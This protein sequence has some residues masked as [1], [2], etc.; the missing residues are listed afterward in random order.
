MKTLLL[1][2]VL[3]IATMLFV[4]FMGRN[5]YDKMGFEKKPAPRA[6]MRVFLASLQL[7]DS[8]TQ[9]QSRFNA[10]KFQHL[11]FDTRGSTLW[12]VDTPWEFGAKNWTLYLEFDGNT[13]L[14]AN[15]K[16]AA[17]RLRTPDGLNI[18]PRDIQFPDRIR[19]GWVSPLEQGWYRR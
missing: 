4:F 3:S 16:L 18:P 5:F 9:V 14:N 1:N 15:A 17:I 7:E 19:R 11:K 10:G 8:A 6:E 12:S 2:V 13:K